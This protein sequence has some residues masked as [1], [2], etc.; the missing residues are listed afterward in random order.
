MFRPSWDTRGL[1][2]GETCPNLRFTL[3]TRGTRFASKSAGFLIVNVRTIQSLSADRFA[4]S[5]P[6]LP[7]WRPRCQ[8]LFFLTDQRPT[9][10]VNNHILS[11][12]S[13]PLKAAFQPNNEVIYQGANHE[14]ISHPQV[15]GLA[16]PAARSRQGGKKQ[17]S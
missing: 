1:R 3:L 15:R 5:A 6:A 7:Q 13:S 12:V 17:M 8:R 9:M 11:P 4:T 10:I 2:S 16:A 14:A